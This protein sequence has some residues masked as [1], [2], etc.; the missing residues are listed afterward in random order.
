MENADH[1]EI[2]Y[3]AQRIA[4]EPGYVDG[5]IDVVEGLNPKAVTLRIILW[6]SIMESPGTITMEEA[7]ETMRDIASTVLSQ[8]TG[9]DM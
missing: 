8:S 1:V 2:N 7:I 3:S 9:S 4:H 6:D 5:M